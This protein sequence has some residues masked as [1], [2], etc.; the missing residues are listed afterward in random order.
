MRFKGTFTGASIDL[1]AY[2]RKVRQHLDQELQ[3]VA[4]AWLG[5]VSGK[6]PVWSGMALGSL[7]ELTDLIDG[8]ISISPKVA[9]R[10]GKGHVLGTAKQDDFLIT[11]TTRVKHYV[12]QEG[13]NVGVSPT[14]PW[15]SFDA[16]KVAYKIAVQNVRLPRL[17][18]KKKITK[19]N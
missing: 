19:V 17:T 8:R 10:I 18:L 7:L 13:K 14:A 4:R 5:A 2:E 6:V 16:G 12:I 11:V 3:R 9:S 15:K 1:N